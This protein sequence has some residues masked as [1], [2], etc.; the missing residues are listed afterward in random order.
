MSWLR[1]FEAAARASSFTQ[2][3]SELSLTQGAVSQQVRELE[4]RLDV[5]LFRRLPRQ[6]LL[7][8]EG[9]QLRDA[10]TAAFD[11][12]ELALSRLQGRRAEG[13][14][15]LSCYSSFAL[16]WLMPRIGDFY[17]R[18]ST[19]DLRVSAEFHA[20]EMA[21]VLNEGIDAAVRYDPGDYR[22]LEATL[23]LDEY[24]LPVASPAFVQAH[25]QLRG[26]EDLD[27]SMLLHDAIAWPGVEPVAE[28]RCCLEAL[29]VETAGLMQ[30]HRF[31]LSQLAVAAA[32]DGQGIAIGRTALVLEHLRDGSLVPL[33]G[34]AVRSPAAYRLVH[35]ARP[36]SRVAVLAQWLREECESFRQQRDEVLPTLAKLVC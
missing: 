4:E 12:L 35:I 22:D 15:A 18:H 2:A 34:R 24:L 7:T 20:L 3:A 31:N 11:G 29:G 27:G 17:R 36:H 9:A 21:T 23:L 10:A 8:D 25:P 14:L 6:L 30:G 26:P 19:I 28:W 13:P 16:L 32:L 5:Q 33:F 1:C